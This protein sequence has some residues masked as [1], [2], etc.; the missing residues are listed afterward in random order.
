MSC[1]NSPVPIPQG[2]AS[3]LR[4]F[5]E[6]EKRVKINLTGW[7]LYSDFRVL[8]DK[9]SATIMT[10]RQTP[11]TIVLDDQSD[12][13]TPREFG[14]GWFQ[15]EFAASDVLV[16]Q[17]AWMDVIGVPGVGLDPVLIVGPL[18]VRIGKTVSRITP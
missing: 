16:A 5:Y 18:Q 1:G 10:Q 12:L 14:R 11:T 17:D 6:D 9:D 8:E 2:V 15:I 4:G 3:V 7:E 13:S